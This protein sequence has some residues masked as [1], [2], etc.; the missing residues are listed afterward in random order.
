MTINQKIGAG[1][2]F[3]AMEA[4]DIRGEQ[5]ELGR[6]ADGAQ[7]RMLVVYRGKHCP[8]CTKYLN[9]LEGFVAE[10]QGTGVDVVAVSADS[11]EQALAHAEKLSVSFPLC[12]GLTV[13]QMKTLG[14][15]ISDPRSPQETDHPF[16]EPG[17][18]VINAKNEV[19]FV[20]ISNNPF[21]RPEI[22][23][24]VSGL[25]WIKDPQNDYPIRGT[26]Q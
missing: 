18:F 12:Y 1:A 25:A 26:Y 21:L 2:Q 8:L 22:D 9:K 6:P 23:A 16:P 20:D 10:L 7:W 17:L 11:A 5:I 3:P 15:Y 14:L 4:R 24:L 13:D 19:Q